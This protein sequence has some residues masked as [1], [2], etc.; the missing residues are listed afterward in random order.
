V[1][2]KERL[3]EVVAGRGA[4]DVFE[5]LSDDACALGRWIHGEGAALTSDPDFQ[6]VRQWHR[7]FHA[8]A[9]VVASKAAGGHRAEALALLHG[10]TYELASTRVVAALRRLKRTLGS[11]RLSATGLRLVS[12]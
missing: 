5:T 4:V 7:K 11:E 8:A 3:R 10:A 2:W 6:Q 12:R 9:G 1:E